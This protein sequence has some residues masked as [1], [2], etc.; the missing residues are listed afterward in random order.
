MRTMH[1]LGKYRFNEDAMRAPRIG[2]LC[3]INANLLQWRRCTVEVDLAPQDNIGCKD[4]MG[5]SHPHGKH[6]KP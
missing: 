5:Q 3:V 4:V 2:L 6:A 1:G